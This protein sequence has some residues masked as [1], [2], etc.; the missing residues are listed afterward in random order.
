M[1]PIWEWITLRIVD[2][3][4]KPPSSE[5]GLFNIIPRI[6]CISIYYFLVSPTF[7]LVF[8]II[9][10][11]VK[12]K[13]ITLATIIVLLNG[14]MLVSCQKE[15]VTETVKTQKTEVS[16]NERTAGS[17][18]TNGE[19]AYYDEFGLPRWNENYPRIVRQEYNKS[20]IV[21]YIY[22]YDDK[23][24]ILTEKQYGGGN[25]LVW[26]WWVRHDPTT[27]EVCDPAGKYWCD[28]TDP[29][30]IGAKQGGANKVFIVI[31]DEEG[32]PPL[33]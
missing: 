8:R 25:N 24:K 9:T 33:K 29:V 7:L 18:W 27:C 19:P 1:T 2:N 13:F 5:G 11:A 32:T 31:N 10:E 26:S 3:P 14:T 12:Q 22:T 6:V 16:A 4:N 21:T 30:T 28:C 17:T 23:M 20:A 15:T